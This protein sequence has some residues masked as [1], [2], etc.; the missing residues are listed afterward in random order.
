MAHN[1]ITITT[2]SVLNVSGS[3]EKLLHKWKLLNEKLDYVTVLLKEI[4]TKH[5]IDPMFIDA[6]Q[7]IMEIEIFTSHIDYSSAGPETIVEV[8]VCFFSCYTFF[9]LQ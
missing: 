9:Y 2:E 7:Q 3:N 6:K 1:F 5:K 8:K 4:S